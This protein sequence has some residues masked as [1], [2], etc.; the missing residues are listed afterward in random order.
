MYLYRKPPFRNIKKSISLFMLFFSGFFF[1]QSLVSASAP[2]VAVLPF[3]QHADFSEDG[4][5]VSG[6]LEL[7]ISN[8]SDVAMSRVRIEPL[9]PACTIIGLPPVQIPSL[10]VAE[11]KVSSIEVQSFPI[12]DTSTP[13][14]KLTYY[15]GDIKYEEL[16]F[17]DSIL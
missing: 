9:D 1:M 5:K 2:A 16:V 3:V 17:S 10:G 13:L 15:V 4:T 14:W 7:H 11:K 12:A 6:K 8:L